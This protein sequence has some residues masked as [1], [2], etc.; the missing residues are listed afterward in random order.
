MQ[1]HSWKDLTHVEGREE[2]VCT[3]CGLDDMRFGKDESWRIKTPCIEPLGQRVSYEEL[4]KELGNNPVRVHHQGITRERTFEELVLCHGT[5]GK[6]RV[7]LYAG[8]GSP[9]VFSSPLDNDGSILGHV[10]ELE[11][12]FARL[13]RGMRARQY[14]PYRHSSY[15]YVLQLAD[16][17]RYCDDD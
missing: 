5:P 15:G 4:V 13:L 12:G 11:I 17:P 7:G 9:F 3:V 2:R 10:P 14:D 6:W 16:S 1:E 8:S